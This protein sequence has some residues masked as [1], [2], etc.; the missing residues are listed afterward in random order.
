MEQTIYISLNSFLIN[1]K[2]TNS[3]QAFVL[4]LAI[5]FLYG[6]A[7]PPKVE[8]EVLPQ[9]PEITIQVASINLANLKKRIERK[10]II[11]LVKILKSEQ[12]D[13]L[14]VQGISRYPGVATRIDFMNEL[15]AKT[16]WRN[17]FGEMLNISG[18]QTGNAIFSEYP[19]LS[20][21]NI[22]WDRVKSTYFDAALQAIVDVGARPLI[23]VST[24]LPLKATENEKAQCLKLIAAMNPDT[25]DQLTIVAGNMPTDENI[26][27]TNLFAEVPSLEF[28]KSTTSRI[29]Y[30][31]N[32]SIQLFSSRSLET[33]LGTLV[34]AQFG[35]LRQQNH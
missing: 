7:T 6:C 24:Q 31:A 11:E 26:R 28:A 13:I 32:T 17:A 33:E 35:L 34:I 5:L 12:V 20:H 8:K 3:L 14:A 18:R 9:K 27:T 1:R 4:T 21:R 25:T 19:I 15:S 29:W 10:N 23:V 22:S 2:K 16:E 30:S